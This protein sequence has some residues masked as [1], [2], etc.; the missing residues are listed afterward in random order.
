MHIRD[1]VSIHLIK[2]PF[3]KVA[4]KVTEVGRKLKLKV[5]K[6]DHNKERLIFTRRKQFMM[7][8]TATSLDEMQVGQKHF[9]M[10]VK[11]MNQGTYC[12]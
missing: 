11:N 3:V 6:I 12:I 4:H 10:V 1:I 7:E 8:S 5:F 9:G 2:P